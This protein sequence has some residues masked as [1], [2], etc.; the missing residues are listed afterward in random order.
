MKFTHTQYAQALHEALQDSSPKDQDTIIENFIEILK[1]K[2]DLA[3]YE[4]IITAYESYDKELKGIIDVEVTTA[5]DTSLSTNKA[6]ID[7]LNAIAGKDTA[8][9]HKIDNNLIGGVVIK[10][11]D[12]L[13]DGSVKHDLENLHKTLT[14]PLT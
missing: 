12:I 8:I 3:E 10:A 11:G 6:F 14:E 13:I 7:K 5:S 1:K 4:K 2:G 9:Q